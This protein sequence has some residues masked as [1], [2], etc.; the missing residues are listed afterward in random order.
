MPVG[1]EDEVV[2]A[3]FL[4]FAA[5]PNPDAVAERLRDVLGP[6]AAAITRALRG[7]RK[8]A[9]MRQA[10]ERLT[11]LYDLSKSFGSTIDLALLNGIIARKAVDFGT[12]EVGSLWLFG[13][14]GQD[15]VLAETVVNE[16]YEV[17]GA[18]SS[19]GSAVAGDVLA[20]R[21]AVRRNAISPGD[22]VS[23]EEEGFVN[24][25]LLA[26]PLVEGDQTV[27]VLTLVNKR[28]RNPEFTAEDE[29][30][31]QDLARQ[32]VRALHNARQYEA[33]K[34]VEELDA[35]LTVS[36][37]ITAT[38]DLDK[39][40]KRIVNA[41]AALIT[42]DQCAIA[43]M[44]RGKLRL[45]A[46]S[47]TVT[48]DRKD[49][50]VHAIQELLEWVFFS[51]SD[52]AAIQDAQGKIHTD[53]AET[54]AETEEKFRGFFQQ[55]GFRSFHG[56][57][58]NDEEGKLGLLAFFR[59]R[60]LVLDEDKRDLLA[61]LVNQA[62]VAVRNAQLYKQIPL[63]GF[64]RPLA[65]RRRKFLEIPRRRR[66]AWT[67]GAAALLILLFAVPWRL[68]IAGPARILPGRR[69]AVTAGVDGTLL[70]VLH[71]EGDRVA[72]GEI[73]ATLDPETYRSA[74]ADARSAFQIADSD[75]AKFQEAGD[76]AAMFEAAS[77]RDEMKARLA[78]E[79]DR[80][81][82]TALRA[83]VAGTIVTPRIEERV[84]Q[85]LTKGAE[86]CVVADLGTVLA[87][88]AIPEMDA[89]FVRTGQRVA[90]KLNPYPT[91]VF[92]GT[93][94]RPGSHVRIE[95]ENSFVIAETT[96]ENPEGLQTGMQG[97]AKVLTERGP[98]AVAI[99]RKPARW[100][101]RKVWPML[102]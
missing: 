102:P 67:I 68:R 55:T 70:S 71:R 4:F 61:I 15:L 83:P 25:S 8:T 86:L 9:G 40:M 21:R 60:P 42:Y 65:E 12:A 26:V 35:L 10:I 36:R 47:G 84:G 43:I 58:L 87:E 45:G 27:G 97:T 23:R 14:E 29:E 66:L 85:L 31:I 81:E 88:V 91:R 53:S 16:N 98:I 34:K 33:Q 72:A 1:G 39:V 50:Q 7:E 57:L 46:I 99:F 30:L 54:R 17:P 80:F 56:L 77:R 6:S 59:K 94:S 75:V 19:V 95:G 5:P 63:P 76:S 79:E 24:R 62:T 100:I 101:W 41:T 51:G 52:V 82:R 92:R 64:L 37:E 28:G 38:L 22:P 20:D 73:I 3:L 48:V 89:S 96:V 90:L 69:A 2:A 49:A 11:A 18:P 74:V 78:L 93:I 13:E 44:D 32:A